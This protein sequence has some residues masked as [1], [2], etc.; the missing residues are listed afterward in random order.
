MLQCHPDWVPLL[1]LSNTEVKAMHT[2]LFNWRT[3]RQRALTGNNIAPTA[4][5]DEAAPQDVA[6]QRSQVDD[7]AQKSE[8]DEAAPKNNSRNVHCT[9]PLH[10]PKE[11]VHY[12]QGHHRCTVDT[13][14]PFGALA[15]ETLL[16]KQ[17]ATS[18]CEDF[19]IELWTAS[20]LKARAQTFSHYKN[21]HTIKFLI[22]I[23]PLGAISFISKGW[24]GCASDK[25]VT[26]NSG[27]LHKLTPILNLLISVT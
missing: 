8:V 13:P 6:A 7:V 14:Q 10:R 27:L 16:A 15:R 1:Y 24:G 25:Y 26:E 23:T 17:H 4:Q 11:C 19:W 22:G 12:V 18:V 20:N 21:K 5:L 2:K 9:P 3:K